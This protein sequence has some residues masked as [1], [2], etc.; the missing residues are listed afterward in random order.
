MENSSEVPVPDS[1]TGQTPN[2]FQPNASEGSNLIKGLL[3][4]VLRR[5]VRES[6]SESSLDGDLSSA[7]ER[8]RRD[9]VIDTT[10][11]QPLATEVSAEMGRMT[12][13]KVSQSL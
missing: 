8:M 4:K 7:V 10:K 12:R 11:Q 5:G 2:N 1:E 6:S 13:A 3:G 9:A